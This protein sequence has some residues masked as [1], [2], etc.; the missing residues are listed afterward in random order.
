M[1]F[2][3]AVS[4]AGRFHAFDLARQLQK[5]GRLAA[6]YT[7][8]P[9]IKVDADLRQASR[10]FPWLY[11]PHMLAN[12]VGWRWAYDVSFWAVAETFDRW[13]A[14]H[15]ESC[16]IVVA[17][18]VYG[19]HTHRAA[20]SRYAAFTVCERGSA[21]ILWQNRILTEE[22]TRHGLRFRGIDRRVIEKEL[23][24]YTTANLI[25]V[26][27]TFAKQTF[28][29]QGVSATK[30]VTWPTG[31]DTTLFYPSPK[32]DDVFRVLYVGQLS[33]QKGTPYLLE[34]F[35]DLRLPRF[36]VVCIGDMQKEVS[37]IWGKYD[38]G[39]FRYLGFVPRRELHEHYSQGSV[40]VMPSIHE[41]LAQVMGQAMACGLPVV[42]TENTG[43]QDLFTNGLEGFIVPA[44][45]AEALRTAV[46]RLYEDASLRD[47]MAQAAMKRVQQIGG[48][49]DYGTRALTTLS[50]ALQHHRERHPAQ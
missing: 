12:R 15:L 16:D 1:D 2:R 25:A 29:E 28:L 6:F 3:V 22:Y 24:E 37:R 5:R 14:R 47:Q 9:R 30:L 19:L 44:R 34:A 10:S 31:V 36:E 23:D 18:S 17:V 39:N 38:S 27:S 13:V 49:D 32:Q 7:A 35:A 21:H 42:A 33:I 48:W 8:Y 41:G 40:F 11:V 26:P 4:S 20:Q 50:E 46:L 43:A 45:N